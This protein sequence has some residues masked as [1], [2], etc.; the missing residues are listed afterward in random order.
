MIIA[1][2]TKKWSFE[3]IPKAACSPLAGKNQ[4]VVLR[5][6]PQSNLPAFGGEKA[7]GGA[8]SKCLKQEKAIS[9]CLKQF[10]CLTFIKIFIVNEVN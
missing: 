6:N 1:R 8:L 10:F 5:V 7:K 3:Q 9:F 2:P 4:K